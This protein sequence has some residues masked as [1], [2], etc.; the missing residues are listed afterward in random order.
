MQ[1][2]TRERCLSDGEDHH[3]DTEARRRISNEI[4]SAFLGAGGSG[5]AQVALVELEEEAG[6]SCPVQVAFV[7]GRV[8][9]NGTG[10]EPTQEMFAKKTT[11]EPF[12]VQRRV[13]GRAGFGG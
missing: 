4:L 6:G 2:S 10:H 5:L 3:R 7:T 12:V 8:P 9:G 1:Q 13:L 11:S